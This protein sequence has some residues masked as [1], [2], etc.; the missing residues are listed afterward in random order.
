[1]AFVL[2]LFMPVPFVFFKYGPYIRGRS[3]LVK[4]K[5]VDVEPS[6]KEVEAGSAT[7][8]TAGAT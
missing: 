2:L 3:K 7:T 6:L 4:I 5:Q 8:L 1:M